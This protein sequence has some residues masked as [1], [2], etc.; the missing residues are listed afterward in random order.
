MQSWYF[1]NCNL[2]FWNSR[3]S[4]GQGAGSCL[5]RVKM[6]KWL[7]I[8]KYKVDFAEFAGAWVNC[9]KSEMNLNIT[10]IVQIL[11]ILPLRIQNLEKWARSVRISCSSGQ[12]LVN[13]VDFGQFTVN[14]ESSIYHG[15]KRKMVCKF[16]IICVNGGLFGYLGSVLGFLT[17]RMCTNGMDFVLFI[18]WNKRIHL[19]VII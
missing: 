3:D 1:A 14:F 8:N 19:L 13:W 10:W 17:V 11:A 2:R 18:I 4:L 7:Q 5:T 15:A 9:V 12:G 16:H 6:V